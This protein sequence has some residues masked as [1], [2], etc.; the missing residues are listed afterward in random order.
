MRISRSAAVAALVLTLAA[1]NACGDDEDGVGTLST[2]VPK[3][4]AV[5]GGNSQTGFVTADLEKSLS[6]AVTD[7]NGLP[8]VGYPVAW[9]VASGGGTVSAVASSGAATSVDTVTTNAFGESVVVWT[10]GNAVGAQSVTAN[11]VGQPTIS[12]AFSATAVMPSFAIEAGN[13]QTAAAKDTVADAPT[14]LVT[15]ANGD[16]VEGVRVDFAIASGGGFLGDSVQ[17]ASVATDSKGLASIIW[18]LGPTVGTQTMTAKVANA[19]PLT[20]TAI[21]TTPVAFNFDVSMRGLLLVDNRVVRARAWWFAP[22][23]I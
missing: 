9:T 10:L 7:A 6:V 23:S 2:P 15:D 21:A 1:L 22:R 3:A 13:N 11:P 4:L 20:F 17:T 19:A 18:V 14:I 5:S 16:P 12:A 8:I